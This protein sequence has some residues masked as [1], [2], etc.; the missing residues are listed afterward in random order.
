MIKNRQLSRYGTVL[1]VSGP[2]GVGKSTVCTAVREQFP[3]LHFSVSCTTRDPRPGEIDGEHYYFI[4]KTV[5][6][7]KIAAGEFIEHADVF[8]NYYGTLHSEV[9]KYISQGED[10]FLDIDIQ[11]AMQIKEHTGSDELLKRC[12]EFIFIIP[13]DRNEL[14]SR[15]RGRNTEDEAVIQRRLAKS[16]H[17]LSFWREYDYI[18]VNDTVEAAVERMKHIIH[19]AHCRTGRYRGI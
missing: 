15:L 12:C 8:G 19:A 14:E 9:V 18:I 17:E 16:E 1:I 5:F 11:G 3:K 6:E 4:N 7:Q 10:V 13:P 2:S